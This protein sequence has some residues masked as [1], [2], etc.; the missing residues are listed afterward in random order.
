VKVKAGTAGVV[1]WLGHE[2]GHF[3]L[4]AGQFLDRGLEPE[5]P[6]GGV[7]GSGVPQVDLELTGG[8][9][10]VRG[11]HVQPIGPELPQRPEE[12]V[13]RVTLQTGDVDVAGGI[14]VPRP[15]CRRRRVAV[16]QVELKFGAHD[17]VHAQ[18]RELVDDTAQHLAWAF[19]GRSAV[20]VEH[21]RHAMR[22][23]GF[24]G[25]VA[26]RRQV[27]DGDHIGHPIGAATL[28]VDLPALRIG[29][30]HRP[31]ERHAAAQVPGQPVDQDIAAAF[32]ADDVAVAD[33]QHVDA[34]FGQGCGGIP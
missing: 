15:S 2:R 7:H 9:F 16:Q 1:E 6:V 5:C 8:E 34:L 33:S 22:D 30:I 4:G 11:D 25:Q 26:Q 21:V 3:V 19:L 24:P 29:A 13:V 32:G 31:A 14:A 10:V 12:E 20:R 28:D 23:T 27:R 17:G 18:G